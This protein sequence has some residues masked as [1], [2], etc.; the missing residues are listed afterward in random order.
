MIEIDKNKIEQ[1][2]DVN[3]KLLVE[4]PDK[5]KVPVIGQGTWYLGEKLNDRE[6]EIA[7]LRLGIELGM[8]LIDT[9]EM[10]GSGRSEALVGE[11]IKGIRDS[12][13]LVSKVY[14]HNSGLNNIFKS[15]ENSLKRLGTDHLD[16][17]L[18]HWRGNVPLEETITGM[19]KLK[20]QGKILRWGVSNFDTED[21]KELWECEDGSN[22]VTN[23]VLYHLGSRGIEFDLLPW[24][25]I[26]K[27]PIMAYCPVAQ[28]GSLRTQLLK[29]S[30]VNRIAKAHNVKPLQIILAWCLRSKDIIAIP[31]AAKVEHVLKNAEA[32]SIV[33]SENE[34]FELDKAFPAPTRKVSLDIV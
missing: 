22:C 21:M 33:L 7:A 32:A 18:L 28:G 23:Q 1:I 17:Y 12:I 3:R 24:Q 9:A 2:A 5:T 30:S 4:L 13:F 34:L 8:T 16:L 31:K 11:A 10:Y 26:H 15:C 6:R 14:P 29:N 19:E 27:M 25:R 20:K